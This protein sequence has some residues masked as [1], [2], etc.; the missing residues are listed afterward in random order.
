MQSSPS[1]KKLRAFKASCHQAKG[2]KASCPPL[3]KEDGKWIHQSL[4]GFISCDILIFQTGM[5][6]RHARSW[7]ADEQSLTCRHRWITQEPWQHEGKSGQNKTTRRSY[8][9]WG[10]GPFPIMSSHIM[11]NWSWKQKDL[12][13]FT[14]PQLKLRK[15]TEA[16][17]GSTYPLKPAS[18]FQL[19]W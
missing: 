7:Q 3:D 11:F 12:G 8:H 16:R 2:A 9:Q 5:N 4:F 15:Q 13:L 14:D 6:R 10:C 19:R 17:T 1:L 18:A